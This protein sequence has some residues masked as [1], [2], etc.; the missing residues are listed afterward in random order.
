VDKVL[1]LGRDGVREYPKEIIKEAEKLLSQEDK[2]I[3][4]VVEA[5]RRRKTI[6]VDD[7]EFVPSR[8]GVEVYRDGDYETAWRNKAIEIAFFGLQVRDSLTRKP[9]DKKVSD[10]DQVDVDIVVN[11]EKPEQEKEDEEDLEED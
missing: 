10:E 8:L 5:W 4:A 3:E 6:E 1:W 7:L 9:K 2:Y 11:V